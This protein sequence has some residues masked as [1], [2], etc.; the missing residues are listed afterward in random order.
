MSPVPNENI[1]CA[2]R[3]VWERLDLVWCVVES[4]LQC[5][6]FRML[7][8]RL[9]RADVALTGL[10]NNTCAWFGEVCSCC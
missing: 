10:G 6:S 2:A 5:Y 8:P 4:M 1:D 9:D 3:R 7:D